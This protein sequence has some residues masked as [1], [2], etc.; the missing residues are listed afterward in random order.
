MSKFTGRLIQGAVPSDGYKH[1]DLDGL[2][3]DDHIQYLIT[4]SARIVGSP[5][6]GLT[7]VDAT[8]GDIFTLTNAG[9]GAALSIVQTGSTTNSDAAVEITNTGNTQRGLSV[10]SNQATPAAALVQFSALDS[11]FD[12]PVL[13]L[14]HADT[15][16]LALK[17][18]A[19][20]YVSTQLEVGA[21]VV[22][23]QLSSNPFVLGD[24][25]VYSKTID[26]ES[27]FYFVDSV[28]TERTWGSGSGGSGDFDSILVD[29]LTALVVTDNISGNVVTE[30]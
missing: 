26:G 19:D 16:G 9:S 1:S 6:S 10:F 11:A 12:E 28:G 17:V 20:A 15:R 7:K 18:E 3:E 21:G 14:T 2:N 24:S 29:N 4:T 25:G 23:G 8:A 13:R 5:T 22:L 27:E 30:E